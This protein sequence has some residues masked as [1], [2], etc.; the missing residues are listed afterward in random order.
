MVTI[1]S[2]TLRQNV[3]ETIYDI[4]VGANLL[5]GSV[6]VT[7]AYVD[8]K[9]AF[10]QVVIR[11]PLADTDKSLSSMDNSYV[12]R[13]IDVVLD[14]WTKKAKELDQISDE[15]DA[16]DSLKS[17]SGLQWIGMA[18]DFAT[19][20]QNNNKLHLKTITLSYKR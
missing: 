8:E 4:L 14:I 11:S 9:S 1:T 7:A 3:Y 13:R 6:K 20:P 2:S 15:I 16:L 10:P 17:I 18:E 5:S 12:H 19:S